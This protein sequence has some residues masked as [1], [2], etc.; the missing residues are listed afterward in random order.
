M[1]RFY[2]LKRWIEIFKDFIK[3]Y[4][5]LIL[6]CEGV[7]SIVNATPSHAFNDDDKITITVKETSDMLFQSLLT[8]YRHIWFDD[9]RCVEVLPANLRKFD[10]N[11]L[12]YS[13][14]YYNMS[15]YDDLLNKDVDKNQITQNKIF[16][17]IKKLADGQFLDNALKYDFNHHLI[18]ITGAS[19]NNEESGK[20]FFGTLN[21]EMSDENI[22]NTIVFNFKFASYKGIF[23][24]IIGEIDFVKELAIAAG[25]DAWMKK[26]VLLEETN[27][28]P[29]WKN[30]FNNVGK[31][32][33]SLAVS[34]FKE[35]KNKPLE[36]LGKY[37]GKNT[38]IGNALTTLSDPTLIAKMSK[39]TIDLGIQ[40]AEEA[41]LGKLTTKV[42]NI[43]LNNFS[44]DFVD[45]YQ[46]YL[47]EYPL[48]IA[49]VETPEKSTITLKSDLEITELE[50]TKNI[51]YKNENIYTRKGF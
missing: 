32:M 40:Y 26:R 42:N 6:T 37:V 27:E 35:L 15:L 38:A 51:V 12:I 28:S 29:A 13:A 48:N 8:T 16:P 31:S 7:D 2:M 23:N 33:K 4:D 24:N 11:I 50:T 41:T 20:T 10:L 22:K 36:Y 30:F 1:E 19:I 25:H 47:K 34:E 5:F 3:N 21:N 44:D 9:N 39:N 17:T 45:V 43:I 46:K 18:M 14:G 49:L